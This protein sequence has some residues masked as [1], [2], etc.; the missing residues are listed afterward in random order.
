MFVLIAMFH[1]KALLGTWNKVL[2][3]SFNFNLVIF[4][5]LIVP[6][7]VNNLKLYPGNET[8]N[9]IGKS[10]ETQSSRQT[11]KYPMQVTKDYF[12]RLVTMN[13]I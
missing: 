6:N 1:W 7:I 5:V 10:N 3:L 9:Q 2:S 11:T 8:A 12:R 4:V 13:F